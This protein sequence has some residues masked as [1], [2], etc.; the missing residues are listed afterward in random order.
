M[1]TLPSGIKKVEASDNANIVNFNRNDDL[2]DAQIVAQNAHIG[3]GGTAHSVV[4]L[5]TAG[6][7]SAADKTKLDGITAGAGGANSAT[8]TV[9]GTR[10]I[11]DTVVAAPGSD[12]PT[13]LWSKLAYM[14]KGI[15]GSANWYTL[16]SMTIAAIIENKAN[17]ASPQLTGTPTATTAAA[18]TNSTQIATT[19]FTTTAVNNLGVSRKA[20]ADEISLPATS[21]TTI[22][23]F[24]PPVRGNYMV[25]VYFRLLA[26]AN[27]TIRVSY[28][29][30]TG[31]Q[32]TYL[33]NVQPTTAGSYSLIPCYICATTSAIAVRATCSVANQMAV[34]ATIMGV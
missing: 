28:S 34:S 16:P 30:L 15:T 6:F 7:S 4:T 18:G 25:M 27:V 2:I 9:I 32:S 11:D 13:R 3:A 12:T 8:D 20:N 17:S 19:A 10:I 14:I 26:T 29:D 23:T 22:A 21:E 1:L 31:A 24:T 33:L 5:T